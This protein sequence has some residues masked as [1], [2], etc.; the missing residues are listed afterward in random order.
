MG[1]RGPKPKS[2]VKIKWSS[3]F[4]YAVGLIV[5][6]GNLSPDGRHISFTSKDEEQV[7]N[8]KKSLNINCY[9]GRKSNGAQKEKKYFVVQFGDVVFYH[10]L[11]A[12]GITSAKS[13]TIGKLKIPK[14]Y[15]FDF[16]RGHLDGDGC[17]YSYWD[18]RWRSS[19]MYYTE[20]ITASRKHILWLQNEIYIRL[21]IKGHI[22]GS[23]VGGTCYQLKYA[24]RES[25]ILLNRVYYKKGLICLKRKRLKI[26][27]ILGSIVR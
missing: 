15:F 17:F 9:I 26:K 6:D 19:F 22:T 21:K 8:Y 27:K 18:P 16:L 2:K 20:L 5:T 23:G 11:G 1:K 10:F 13:K 24:K 25:N 7:N 3:A 4:A 14:E 12:I